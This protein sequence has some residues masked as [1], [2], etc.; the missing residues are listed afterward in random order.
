MDFQS[1][2]PDDAVALPPRF[3]REKLQKQASEA[4]KALVGTSAQAIHFAV[5]TPTSIYIGN[6]L[7]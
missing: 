5:R 1:A 7:A 3:N 2:T 4:G 6:V